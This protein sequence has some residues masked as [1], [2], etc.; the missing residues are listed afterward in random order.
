MRGSREIVR[1][2]LPSAVLSCT[3]CAQ[4]KN[5]QD[6]QRTIGRESVTRKGDRHWVEVRGVQAGETAERVVPELVKLV[7]EARGPNG[8]MGHWRVA[9]G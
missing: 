4:P 8:R 3:L 1:F 6:I 9:R 2:A 7:S 5:A